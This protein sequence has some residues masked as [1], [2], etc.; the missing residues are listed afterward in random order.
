MGIIEKR[1]NKMYLWKKGVMLIGAFSV[2]V[3]VGANRGSCYERHETDGNARWRQS[4]HCGV[5]CLYA[6]MI[7]SGKTI[8][9]NEVADKVAVDPQRGTSLAELQEEL[10]D[11]ELIWR[12]ESFGL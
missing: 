7:Y 8:P 9:Y 10:F 5:N 11:L 1:R 4:G 3:N 12:S 2:I 6:M